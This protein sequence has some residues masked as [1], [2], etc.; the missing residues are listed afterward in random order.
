[1]SFT[2][3]RINFIEKVRTQEATPCRQGD[4]KVHVRQSSQDNVQLFDTKSLRLQNNVDLSH[5]RS[6]WVCA[7]AIMGIAVINVRL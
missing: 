1:M 7:Q 4:R 2:Q 5:K 3:H 6:K